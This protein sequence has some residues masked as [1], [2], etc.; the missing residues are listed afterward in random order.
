MAITD[1]E[2]TE[3]TIEW[4]T[5]SFPENLNEGQIDQITNEM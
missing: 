1:L 3:A 2:Q 5:L 4:L